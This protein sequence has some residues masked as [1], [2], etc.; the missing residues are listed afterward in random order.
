[1][2]MRCEERG[3]GTMRAESCA[4]TREVLD[5]ETCSAGFHVQ[6]I[7]RIDPDYRK[8]RIGRERV[9]SEAGDV[10]RAGDRKRIFGAS[11]ASGAF[12]VGLESLTYSAYLGTQRIS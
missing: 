3:A 4:G 10:V 9:E 5:G 8:S 7:S 12:R 2:E 6:Y 11:G 1:M